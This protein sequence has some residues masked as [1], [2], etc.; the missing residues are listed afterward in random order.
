MYAIGF[1]VASACTSMPDAAE[2]PSVQVTGLSLIEASDN[3]QR[4]IVSLLLENPNSVPMVFRGIEFNV[5][6][7]GEGFI[8]GGSQEPLLLSANGRKTMRIDVRSEFVSSVSRLISYLQGPES[9]IPYQLEGEFALDT[10]PPR[11]LS[12]EFEGRVPLLMSAR[13]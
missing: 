11:F 2:T 12:F 9:T 7:S 3:S 4:F 5:R 6:L 8:E 10:R 13:Q 1:M